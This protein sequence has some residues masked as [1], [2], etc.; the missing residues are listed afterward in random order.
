MKLSNN[1]TLSEATKSAT[2]TKYGIVNHPDPRQIEIMKHLAN[3]LFQPV[4]DHFG[5][6]IF[7]S[8]FFRSQKLNKRV[9]KSKRSDHMIL[10][11]IAAIDMDGDVFKSPSNAEI[12]WYIYDNMPYY[13]LIWEF[14]NNVNP[15]WVHVSFSTDPRKNT[16]R[17]TFH[18]VRKYGNV[19]YPPFDASKFRR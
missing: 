2:A 14:G 5:K 4:R 15:S 9:S 19:D 17:R 13:K 8:S 12:F 1:L 3:N 16:E 10:G 11:D 18:A 7:V 6:P